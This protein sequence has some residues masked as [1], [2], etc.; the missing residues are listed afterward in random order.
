MHVAC[1][2]CYHCCNGQRP[3]LTGVFLKRSSSGKL[4]GQKL[5][6]MSEVGGALGCYLIGWMG[7]P[8]VDGGIPVSRVTRYVPWCHIFHRLGD[9]LVCFCVMDQRD[10]LWL[11]YIL[12]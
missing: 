4:K 6:L 7:W 10:V 9:L 12:V 8:V 1:V 2:S 5:L 11:E 3:V